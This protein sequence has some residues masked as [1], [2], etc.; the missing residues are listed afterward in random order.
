MSARSHHLTIGIRLS[1]RA[2]WLTPATDKFLARIHHFN[3]GIDRLSAAMDRL[4]DVIAELS[5]R[6][7]YLTAGIDIFS[8]SDHH[9]TV[10]MSPIVSYESLSYCWN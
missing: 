8:A 5:N 4:T 3:A 7:P 10:G 9:L 1:G 6:D 2:H